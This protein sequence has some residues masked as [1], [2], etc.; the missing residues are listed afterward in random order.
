M[1]FSIVIVVDILLLLV[2]IVAVVADFLDDGEIDLFLLVLFE[3]AVDPIF[4]EEAAASQ[5][6][7]FGDEACSYNEDDL[8]GRAPPSL[9]WLL[10]LLLLL[11]CVLCSL[12]MVS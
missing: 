5:L 3:F 1:D 7:L 2:I 9:L 6:M 11:Y 10:L 8:E 12:W 4:K